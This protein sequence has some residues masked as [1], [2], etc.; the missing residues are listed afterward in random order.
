MAMSQLTL[1]GVEVEHTT[2]TRARQPLTGAQREIL[3]W[4]RANGKIRAFEAGTIVHAHREPPCRSRT[5]GGGITACCEHASSDGVDALKRLAN[6]GLV[7]RVARGLYI[8]N[9]MR[10]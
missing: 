4:L 7:R 3:R 10:E 9:G 8:T 5:Q 2:V 6:R 1:D